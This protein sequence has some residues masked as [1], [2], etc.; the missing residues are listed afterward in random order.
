M[1][2]KKVTPLMTVDAIEPCLPFWVDRLGFEKVAEVPDG[3]RLGFVILVKDGVELMY[4]SQASV[5]KDLGVRIPAGG[6]LYIEVEDLAPILK[7]L[8]GAEVV[9]PERTTFY[10]AHEIFVREPGGHVVGFA[11][12]GEH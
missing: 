1:R 3:D 9:V 10:G 2:L 8:E 11:K 5:E 6:I 7:A 4:Q 12:H